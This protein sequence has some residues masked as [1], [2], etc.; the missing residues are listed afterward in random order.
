M[1]CLIAESGDA[2]IRRIPRHS[3]P[4]ADADD[5]AEACAAASGRGANCDDGDMEASFRSVAALE[6]AAAAAGRS[7][8]K[9]I[10][11]SPLRTTRF[12][13]GCVDEVSFAA[14]DLGPSPLAAVVVSP[15][16]GFSG[17]KS[18]WRVDEV[19]VATTSQLPGEPAARF[20]FKGEA[21]G[22]AAARSRRRRCPS[23][24]SSSGPA[25]ARRF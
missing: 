5:A 14:P 18:T 24:P 20:V 3:D 13:R 4:E 25:S 7:S 9:S 21:A 16:G 19:S 23:T 15:Q 10:P 6:K 8:D 22:A 17:G 12:Q 2:V 11:S 1:L